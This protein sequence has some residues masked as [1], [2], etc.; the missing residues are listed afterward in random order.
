MLLTLVSCQMPKLQLP[1]LLPPFFWIDRLSSKIQTNPGTIGH[2][3]IYFYC[4]VM[5]TSQ[6]KMCLCA[7]GAC[8]LSALISSLFLS[9][10]GNC[11][12]LCN[13]DGKDVKAKTLSERVSLL[14]II[15]REK[16]QQQ[17]WQQQ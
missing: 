5:A 12:R 2:V 10:E 9:F 14:E 17:Q 13:I 4:T 1:L 8:L 15:Q 16:L 7:F 3:A 6:C 11:M